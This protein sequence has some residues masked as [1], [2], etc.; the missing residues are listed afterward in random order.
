MLYGV[1]N[2]HGGDRYGDG[3]ALDFSANVSPLGTPKCVTEWMYSPDVH[4]LS[5]G[6]P[7]LPHRGLWLQAALRIS[8]LR[9]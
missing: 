1:K 6:Q 9:P 7:F 5:S 2:P 4:S 8:G 3:I